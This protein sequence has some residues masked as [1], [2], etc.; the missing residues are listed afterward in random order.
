MFFLAPTAILLF[1]L[2]LG[3]S[4]TTIGNEALCSVG[5]PYPLCKVVS[6]PKYD[7]CDPRLENRTRNP[8][9]KDCHNDS[10]E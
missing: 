2:V 3:V 4:Q 5:A 10:P 7:P 6:S 1:A 9:F 8:S